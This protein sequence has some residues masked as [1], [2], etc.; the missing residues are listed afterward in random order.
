MSGCLSLLDETTPDIL[1]GWLKVLSLETH[2][3]LLFQ[4]KANASEACLRE[5][6]LAHPDIAATAVCMRTVC[7][8]SDLRL[9]NLRQ[10]CVAA[11]VVLQPLNLL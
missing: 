7:P 4:C 10:L 6:A 5:S 2:E 1:A 9:H 8:V 11:L 3:L